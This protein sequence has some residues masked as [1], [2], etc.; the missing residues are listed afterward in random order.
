M[1]H[2]FFSEEVLSGAVLAGDN[3]RVHM[4]GLTAVQAVLVLVGAYYVF[5][6]NYPRPYS[7]LLGFL[8]QTVVGQPF[9]GHKSR[10]FSQELSKYYT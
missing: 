5:D 2:M 8:Q 6:I 4:P 7:Q 9:S 10:G 1:L 3:V